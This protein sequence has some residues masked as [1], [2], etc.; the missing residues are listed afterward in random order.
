MQPS[1]EVSAPEKRRPSTLS[2]LRPK[3][4]TRRVLLLGAILYAS[5]VLLWSAHSIGV[6]TSRVDVSLLDKSRG[7]LES[8]DIPKLL[9]AVERVPIETRDFPSGNTTPRQLK[10]IGWRATR[11]CSADGARDPE[12]DQNCTQIVSKGE[13]GY[14]EVEDVSTGERFRV[15]RRQCNSLPRHGVPFRCSDAHE[16]VNFRVQAHN[17]SQAALAPSFK[18]PN[19]GREGESPRDGIVMV[20]YPKLLAS[21]YAAIRTLRDVLGCQLPVEIWFRPDEIQPNDA[22]FKPL[23][24][25][26]ATRGNVTFQEIDDPRAK[27][28]VAKIHAI[29][30]STFD[31]V[32]FLDADNVP[33]RDPTFLF[34]SPEFVKTGAVFWPDFW[35]PGSTIFGVHEN[36]LLWEL[37]DMPFVDMFEQE[38]GQLVVDRKRHAAPLELVRFYALH[39]PDFFSALRL[40]WGDK[41]LFRLAWLKLDVPFTMIQTPPGMAGTV[42]DAFLRSDFCGMTMVQH[43]ADGEVLFMHR[44]QHKL[45]GT[46][47]DEARDDNLHEK[48]VDDVDVVSAPVARYADP[49]IWTHLLHFHK[50][51]SRRYYSIQ[52]FVLD[53]DFKQNQKCYG[54]RDVHR[55]PHFYIQEIAALDFSEL[56]TQLRRFALQSTQFSSESLNA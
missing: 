44:N 42:Y 41:D 45:T 51:S 14:C 30:H 25:L 50:G 24:H 32:L 46:F 3:A 17:T 52:T 11:G 12:K 43:D 20:V 5:V 33:V 23:K 49:A 22:S 36:S 2:W 38:S 21:A 31:R 55:N 15:M 7:R 53:L 18:L 4:P 34:D 29:Y 13:R 54:R 16:F 35:H 28:F 48:T 56:E 47:T 26:A 6:S 40:V 9:S 27:R 10:C 37:I 8:V 1:L 19:V 39:R